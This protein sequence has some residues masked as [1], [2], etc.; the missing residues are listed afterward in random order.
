MGLDRRTF[1]Q[2]AGLA[3]LTWGAAETGISSLVNHNLLGASLKNYQ[4]TLA[5]PTSR[6][7]A[8]LIGI[9][10]Y[11]AQDNLAGCI[12]DVELQRELLIHRFGFNPKDI[13]TL[14]DRQA[15]RE[16]IETAFLEH[17]TQQAKPDDVVVF[18]FSGYGG[19]IKMP[20][21]A[22]LPAKLLEEEV[23]A[24]EVKD[25]FRLANS[26]IPA[27]GL[28]SSK[29]TIFANSILQDTLFILAQ[30]LSTS[31]CTFVL[32]T[33]FNTNPRSQH[34]SFKVRSVSQLAEQPSFQELEF[35]TQLQ[36]DF[37][38]KGLKPSKRLLSLPGVVL[39]AAS[40]NQVAVERNWDGLT[41]GLFTQAL[42]QHLWHITPSSKVQVALTRTAETVEQVMGRQQQPTLSNP[43]KSAI[44]Y[45]LAISN[46]P[47]AAGMISKVSKN[48]HAEIK[49]LGLPANIISSYGVNSCFNLVSAP[50][51]TAPQIQVKSKDGLMT[52]TQ[53]L[54]DLE[55]LNKGQLVRES[56]RM[57]D[58]D[59]SLN[60][61]LDADLNRIERVDATSALANIP[62]INSVIVA[63]EQNADCLIGKIMTK[64]ESSAT[65]DLNL[66]NPSFAYGL[67]TAG[68]DLIG[69]TMGVP[70]EAVKIAVDRLRPQFD[71]LLATKWLELTNNEFSSQ[72]KASATLLTPEIKS[73]LWKKSTLIAN[74]SIASLKKPLFAPSPILP[75]GNNN[76]PRIAKGTEIKLNLGNI[77]EQQLHTIILSVDSDFNL[78]ALYTPAQ[79]SVIEGNVHL[80]EIAIAPQAEL[81]LPSA[82][83]SWK[84]KV[85]ESA[86]INTLYVLLS[87]QPFTETLKAFANQQNFKLDQQ[88]VLNVT[89]P[90]NVTHA[91][92]QDLH[93]T[94]AVA[95]ELL[96]ND[97]VY[98]LNVNSWATLKF[99]YEVTNEQP[100][101]VNI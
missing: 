26:F 59:L 76:L 38:S 29:K 98:A 20:L 40:K 52:K 80:E 1:L 87:L 96:P 65:S 85:S 62:A 27:D 64:N 50:E 21:S 82:E 53:P 74:D 91:V 83:N 36:E 69:K 9:N 15:T 8:L 86:G 10:R 93:N 24:A 17:L 100:S 4:Q 49:L 48:N 90:L 66:D 23:A 28:S 95:D 84:W 22:K 31:K 7:L 16:N 63:R 33:S 37:S 71:N 68:G 5:Q 79:S 34:G 39:S 44:A 3:F 92:M 19:Q 81:S 70:E 60:L 32:D 43:D 67:Y 101:T 57:L 72:I 88:Q 2:Q 54:T 89:N 14:S 77:S 6:K 46:A 30:T 47:N 12:M 56:I 41:A 35:L 58:H 61:A 73:P 94:S 99:V 25:N 45:Y 18:H 78:Y 97:N 13:L 51:N 55:P 42:T 11:S 75:E